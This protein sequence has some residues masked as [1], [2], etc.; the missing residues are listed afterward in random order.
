MNKTLWGIIIII[1]VVLGIWY[2]YSSKMNGAAGPQGESAT[3]S[4]ATTSASTASAP[5]TGN[6]AGK[7][8]TAKPAGENTFRSIFTQSGS[9]QCSYEQVTTSSRSSNVIYIADGKMRGEFR[10]S[11]GTDTTASLMV[12]NGGYLYTW[13]E[14]MTTGKRTTIRTIEDL[15]QA[16]PRDLTSGAIIGTDMNSVGWDC[17]EWIKDAKLLTAPSYVR[18]TTAS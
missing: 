7:P 17:H 12:Y 9:H 1:L 5:T 16:I 18:F 10:T 11:Q 4:A 14:G 2:F 3:T 6:T 13:T 15:P 8:T